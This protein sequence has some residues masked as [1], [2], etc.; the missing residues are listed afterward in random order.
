MKEKMSVNVMN[1]S[2]NKSD[3]HKL[4]KN[5]TKKIYNNLNLKSDNNYKAIDKKKIS[6]LVQ[7]IMPEIE[8]DFCSVKKR[9]KTILPHNQ[10]C[11]S[12]KID[13]ER[14]TRRRLMDSDY[15]KCH[16]YKRPNGRYD[17]SMPVKIKRKRGRR[18]KFE[19]DPK[20]FDNKYITV[21]EEFIDG[22][23]YLIDNK[24]R[25]FTY[26]QLNPRYLGI[27]TLEGTIDTSTAKIDDDSDTN[28]TDTNVDNK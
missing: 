9:K 6:K 3:L 1:K 27:K 12:R 7:T 11:M 21:W 28:N 20:L 26:D 2:D 22:D 5:I 4:C 8:K 25:V 14:C 24:C 17:E 19:L 13:G 23:R 15:C 16:T 18:R 10:M